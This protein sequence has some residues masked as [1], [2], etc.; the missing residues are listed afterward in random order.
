[1]I[2]NKLPA[3]VSLQG[4]SFAF[5]DRPVLESISFDIASRD[6][7]AVLGPNGSG[8]TTLLKIILNLLKPQQ[9]RVLIR[10]QFV[11]EFEDWGRIGYIPQKATHVDPYFPAS[12]AEAVSMALSPRAG[13]GSGQKLPGRQEVSRALRLVGMEDFQDRLIGRLSG[14]QQQRVFIARA[15]VNRPYL[16]LLDEPTTGVDAETQ[17]HFY[18]MLGRFNKEEGITIVL[19]THDIGVVDNH[20]TRV[21]CLNQNLTYHGSH[22]EFC[23]SGAFREMIAGGRH[24]VAHRH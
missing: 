6:F 3:L 5:G 24:L 11:E 2:K 1:M 8:K 23:R 7:L 19:V 20:V 18:D 13:R 15:L 12:V 22:R 4:V 14:G 9:G 16:L 10:G 17:E 21:A